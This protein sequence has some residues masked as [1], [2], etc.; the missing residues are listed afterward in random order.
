MTRL[1]TLTRSDGY[2]LVRRLGYMD[3]AAAEHYLGRS[4]EFDEWFALV[5]NYEDYLLER[6]RKDHED[7]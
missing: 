7:E 6:A 4:L 5:D 1:E 3:E 2:D